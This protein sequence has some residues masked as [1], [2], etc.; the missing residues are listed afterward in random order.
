MYLLDLLATSLTQHMHLQAYY[1][2]E[3][4]PAVLTAHDQTFQQTCTRLLFD[5]MQGP[6][7]PMVD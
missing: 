2:T 5:G 6:V 3:G 4:V 7:G 1:A